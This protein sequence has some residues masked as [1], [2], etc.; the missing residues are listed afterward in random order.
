MPLP[1]GPAD[2][3]GNRYELWWTVSEFVNMLHGR[4]DAIRI[5]DPGIEKAEFTV[6]RGRQ[7]TLH[8]AKRA[9]RGGKWSLA[10]LARG[11]DSL[12][13]AIGEELAGNDAGFL[14]VSTSD[15]RELA[16]LAERAQRAESLQEF[17]E[18][19]LAGEEWAKHF[20]ELRN[21]WR[22]D[23]ATA[24]DILRRVEVRTVDERS[25]EQ[26]VRSGLRALFLADLNQLA[27]E[28]R[29]FALDAVHRTVARQELVDHL[30]GRGFL[31][32]RV[33]LES[34]GAVVDEVTRRYLEGARKKL[35]RHA[36][37]PRAATQTL[38]QKVY[39][40][41]GD[42][43][44]TGKAG[45]GKTGC[46]LEFVEAL[47]TQGVPVLAFR[48]DRL[49]PASTTVDLGQRLGLDESPVIVLDAAAAGRAAVLVV[50][51]LDAVSTT[52]GRTSGFFHAVEGLL[53]EVRGLRVRAPLHIVVVC[54][55]FD[56]RNDPQLNQLLSAEHA[57]VVVTEFSV[58]E[59][60]QVLEGAGFNSALFNESQLHLLRLPQNLSLFLEA[61]FD[62]A[63][64]P[65]F[66]TAKEIFDRYW[67]AKRDAV[68]L[69]TVPL[70]DQWMDVIAT[71]SEEMTRTQHL[72][73]A[74]EKLDKISGGYLTQMVS[75][76]VLTFDGQRYGFGHESFFDYCFARALVSGEQPLV[77]FLTDSEQHLFRRA[78]VQ[79]VLTYLRD[80]DR[81]RY[82]DEVR[83][84]L[85]DDRVRVHLKDLALALL[86]GVTDPSDEEWAIFEPWLRPVLK[87]AEEERLNSDKFA[88]LA[89]Q[90]LFYSS[91]W[92][93]FAQQRGL[94][95]DWLASTKN[96]IVN[97]GV[98]YLRVHQRQF[99]ERV[100][101]LVDPYVDRGGEWV[102]RLRFLI[103]W[104]D[105]T[106]SRAFFELVLRLID[107]GTLDGATGPIA[108]HSA[109]WSMLYDL[110]AGRPDWIPEVIGHW[111]RRRLHTIQAEDRNLDDD[112]FGDDS[113]AAEPLQEASERAPTAFVRH[114]LPIVLE[115]ADLA[116]S[117]DAA[118]PKQDA[119]WGIPVKSAHPS[120]ETACLNGL[121]GA[122]AALA[123]DPAVDLRQTVDQLRRRDTYLANFLLHNLYAA[124]GPR[125][126][127]E[128]I[129]L[130]CDEPWR[131][132]C[133][134][135]DSPRWTA[136]ELIRAVS[137]FCS[138]ENRTRLEATLLDYK[139]PYERTIAGFKEAGQARYTLLSGVPSELRGG[140]ANARY[141]ELAR[142]FGEPPRAPRGV[143][144]GWVRSPIEKDA[145][146]KMNDVQWL[147]AIAKYDSEHRHMHADDFLKGGARQL[148]EVLEGYV[149]K[150]PQRF[151]RL[152]LT[153]PPG[154][155]PLYYD[156]ILVGLKG[157]T[158]SS[159]LKLELCR[160][161]YADYRNQCGSGI[162]DLLGSIK[163]TL[164]DDALEMLTWLATEHPDPEREAWQ[165]N[166]GNN[167]PYYG[168]DILTNG[169][170]TTRGRAADAIRDL[171][172]RDRA[173]IA[174]F[175]GTLDRIVQDKSVCVMSCVA[176]TLCAVAYHD[177]PLAFELFAR[178]DIVDDRLLATRHVYDFIL[179]GLRN[180]YEQLRPFIERMLR[181]SDMTVCEA[182]GRLAGIAALEHEDATELVEKA[183]A[184]N[185]K[186]RLGIT[187]V[188]A[189]NIAT[190]DYRVWCEEH[191]VVLFNDEDADVRRAAAQSFR[192]LKDESLE[193][194]EA[195]LRTFCDSKAYAE[196]SFSILH[197]LENSVR[198]LPGM[199][200]VVCERFLA[201]FGDEAKDIRTSRMLEVKTVAKLIFRTYDHHQRDEWAKRAL[202]LIDR[203]CLEA[204]GDARRELE[205]FDR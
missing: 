25:I 133:G 10:E 62:L 63:K 60:K 100:V 155:L 166:A 66:N 88:A 115:I 117:Q 205:A 98:S 27:S 180:R 26:Q 71:L 16:E 34:S 188:A 2:K 102:Q 120:P 167:G 171:I 37:L 77:S 178:V 142:K 140:N 185:E 138:A 158:A 84:L 159:E 172:L 177:V 5:E 94:V 163:D 78:Q 129:A 107:N 79:Q 57:T 90:H 21:T 70:A 157:S 193:S 137:P 45:A 204:I 136:K 105:L 87:A 83:G 31:L 189:A 164:P 61:G 126:A 128:A 176:S 134:F 73:V 32:R 147:K 12:L 17:D 43:L 6:R 103:E 118:S 56:W 91:S 36:L 47:R 89:W 156:H 38:L 30:A 187:E 13:E 153:F 113:F 124:G 190:P 194:Y 173:C 170:N 29:T 148:A 202:D 179:S 75:E 123:K 169:I 80:A 50:D 24:Y 54:R 149:Q 116:A 76:G 195:L 192:Y 46:V 150:D 20:Q 64:A 4:S 143:F 93:A 19:F 55:E 11:D 145:A 82:C 101:A 23:A 72:S 130:L 121:V 112:F 67:A 22:C 108:G 110:V 95:G 1:G 131:F 15:A 48:L 85:A 65:T 141:E 186:G 39:D 114:V 58:D 196:D 28:L 165:T 97:I 122:L 168:G 49:E 3:L 125:F 183:T 53:N 127:D 198:R 86:A 96:G 44:L 8:Q 191:L 174:R 99:P 18:K 154:T 33:T 119:V 175:R 184:G 132:E 40:G 151:A 111:L 81:Q 182:G 52:S 181:S 92:F 106:K 35:I 14:F 109:F 197:L 199:T 139:S 135:S 161:T 51:Q 59:A 69:R 7:R 41:V 200:C 74:R 152:A 162:A 42:S 203:L 160:K 9:G 68:A 144:G 146:D 201:R 104:A